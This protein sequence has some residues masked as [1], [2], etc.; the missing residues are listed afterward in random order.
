MSSWQQVR[1]YFLQQQPKLKKWTHTFTELVFSLYLSPRHSTPRGVQK[2]KLSPTSHKVKNRRDGFPPAE[3]F[4][5]WHMPFPQDTCSGSGLPCLPRGIPQQPTSS[6]L[7]HAFLQK[8]G[9]RPRSHNCPQRVDV[10]RA[11]LD[12]EWEGHGT[13]TGTVPG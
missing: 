12:G 8:G 3:R 7:P 6:S 2:S 1:T 9:L 13:G 4:Y 10:Q 11:L 5:L